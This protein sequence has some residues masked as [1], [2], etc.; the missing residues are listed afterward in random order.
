MSTFQFTPKGVAD[1]LTELYA[2]PD[3]LLNVQANAIK[4]DFKKWMKENFHLNAHQETHLHGTNDRAASD[5]GALCAICF[6]YRLPISL[7]QP[8]PLPGYAKWVV[9]SSTI[10]IEANGSGQA[11]AKGEVIFTIA[12]R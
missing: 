10:G 8:E 5:Y 3:H 7:V 12:Y 6:S 9:A 11:D 4:T 1:K 2:L